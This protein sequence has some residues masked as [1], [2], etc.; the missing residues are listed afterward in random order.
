M[1]NCCC[2]RNNNCA[3]LGITLSVILGIIA[4]FLRFFAVIAPAAAFFWVLLGIGVVYPAVLLFSISRRENS[5]SCICEALPLFTWGTAGTIITSL[6]LLG[7]TF[8]ATSI[9]GA[10]ITGLA[11]GFFALLIASVLCI[12]NC[13]CNGSRRFDEN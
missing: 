7:I 3:V 4:A 9:I 8:A 5:L 10:I 1:L 13:I 12:I 6:L 11:V 2:E